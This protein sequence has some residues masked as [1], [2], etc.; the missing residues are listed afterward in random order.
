ML[1]DAGWGAR[2]YL[3]HTSPGPSTP[4]SRPTSPAPCRG[5]TAA[6]RCR[7]PATLVRTLGGFGIA[8][9]VQVVAYDQDN[10]MFA[11]RLWWLLRWMGH[12]AVAV[13]DGGFARWIAD[14]RPVAAG[15]ET[16][17]R[18]SIRRFAARGHGRRSGGGRAPVGTADRRASSTRGRPNAIAAK[19]SRL[20]VSRDTSP[21]RS[22]TISCRTS[23]NTGCFARPMP[24][25]RGLTA[26][27]AGAR[28]DEAVFYCG[29][30]VTACHNLL[31]LELAGLP[32]ARLYPGS[33][34]EWSSDPSRPVEPRPGPQEKT[35][36][37]CDCGRPVT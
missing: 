5:A 25:A 21:V 28:P 17:A 11:S 34:S 8:D 26:A 6:I 1:T 24:C 20:T 35:G 22:T 15:R 13:L 14:Q 36:R 27:L 9:G 2:E 29:S 19:S 12:H 7:I 10:G 3:A 23:T 16:R 4:T 30:G 33:W 31:A 18:A 37:P 32:G